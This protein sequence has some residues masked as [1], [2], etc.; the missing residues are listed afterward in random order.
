MIQAFC[1]V[2]RQIKQEM[3]HFFESFVTHK[4]K[5]SKHQR[6]NNLHYPRLCLSIDIARRADDGYN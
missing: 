1:C 2:L 3:C 5:N 4:G 6:T